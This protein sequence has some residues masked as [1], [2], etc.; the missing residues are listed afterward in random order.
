MAYNTMKVKKYSDNVEELV[1]AAAITPGMLVEVA[2]AGTVQAH[3][4]AGGTVI[5]KL[6]LRMSFRVMV[7][8]MP[9]QRLIRCRSG[10][11]IVG[12]WC[13]RSLRMVKQ[14][15]SAV[16]WSPMVM[17]PFGCLTSLRRV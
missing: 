11:P 2:T 13:T 4:T 9:T 8:M 17:V 3:S 7:S 14:R 12:T 10:L 5:Q 16:C 6:P 1:A 15:S